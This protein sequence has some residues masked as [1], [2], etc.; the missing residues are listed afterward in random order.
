MPG[1]VSKHRCDPVLMEC[2]KGDNVIQKTDHMSHVELEVGAA[3]VW[4][5]YSRGR[6]LGQE[7]RRSG[8]TPP[9]SDN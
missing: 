9:G 3:R 5:C 1:T 2:E 7:F 8:R 4:A 6:G